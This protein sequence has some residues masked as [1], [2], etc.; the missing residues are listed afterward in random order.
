[1]DPKANLNRQIELAR[2]I[3]EL[4]DTHADERGDLPDNVAQEIGDLANELAELVEALHSWRSKGG[5]DP[6]T[7]DRDEDEIAE[8]AIDLVWLRY[9][10]KMRG[11]LE[12]IAAACEENGV[13]CGKP[14]D[15]SGDDYK[16]SMMA[17]RTR[18]DRM[19]NIA[20]RGIDISVEIAESRSYDNELP[21]GINF[22]LD[23]V[24]WGGR[25][26]GGFTPHNYTDRV[27][28]DARDRE[29]VSDRWE[30]FGHVDLDEIPTL[31]KESGR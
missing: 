17:W 1:M 28:V 23:I 22:G 13:Y 7:E 10:H 4:I 6:Y 5:Y 30:M 2:E 14:F 25:I 26:L 24:E 19:A 29:A 18:S 9:G 3:Q 20:E 16:W 27:W 8:E 21:T 15:M 12:R 11:L 31:I